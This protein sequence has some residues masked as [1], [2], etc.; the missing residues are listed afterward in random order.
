MKKTK[1]DDGLLKQGDVIELANGMNVYASIE[2]R[3]VFSN[4][5]FSTEKS[6]NEVVVGKQ[7]KAKPT[8]TDK[9][10]IVKTIAKDFERS[11]LK[12]SSKKI[13]EFVE[14]EV[15]GKMNSATWKL[16]S[17]EFLV[18]KTEMTGG[19]N[20]VAR[21]DNYPDGHMVTAKRLRDGKFNPDGEIVSFYQTGS[22]TAMITP[23]EIS[24]IRKMTLMYE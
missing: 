4:R 21:G 19:S 6:V 17:G 1:T 5:K 12:V 9:N 23:D 3:F 22:F 2:D 7:Y 18:I 11:G 15:H 16:E 13:A 10:E 20:D 8:L 14:K 24:P